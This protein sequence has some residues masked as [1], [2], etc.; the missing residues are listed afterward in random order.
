MLLSG[1]CAILRPWFARHANGKRK[2]V[3][4]RFNH[5][6]EAD[7]SM[8]AIFISTVCFQTVGSMLAT[9]WQP[10]YFVKHLY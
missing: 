7:W 9:L 5:S 8:Q 1:V 6:A 10:S 3:L 4:R 2:L